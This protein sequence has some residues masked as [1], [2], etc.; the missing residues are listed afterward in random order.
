MGPARRRP[1]SDR[2]FRPPPELTAVGL[3]VGIEEARLDVGL[4]LW[5]LATRSPRS[6]SAP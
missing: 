6:V 2:R 1:G 3:L 4:A 5:Q